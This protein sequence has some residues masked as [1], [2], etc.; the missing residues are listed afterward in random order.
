MQMGH[1]I[2]ILI[3]DDQVIMRKGLILLLNSENDIEV[4]GEAGDTKQTLQKI[5][6][7]QPDIVIME[8]A[9][10]KL[11]GVEITRRIFTELS[12]CKVIALSSHSSPQLIT[13]ILQA[14]ATAYLLKECAPEELLGAIHTVMTGG[15]YLAPSIAAT[16][17]ATLINQRPTSEKDEV[18]EYNIVVSS[19]KLHPPLFT[20]DLI[21]RPVLLEYLATR[22]HRLL[23]LV[24]APA[25]YGKSTLIS[26][27]LD[28][29]EWPCAWLTLERE[30]G[31][32]RQFLVY[33]AA[34]ISR[35][36]PK[37]LLATKSLSKQATLP[38][39]KSIALTL[40]NDLELLAKPFILVLDNFRFINAN[41]Q[42]H[43]LLQ[44]LLQ[45]TPMWL[46]LIILS[47]CDPLLGLVEHR[48]AG[49]LT[50]IRMQHLMFD[51][52]EVQLLH[53]KI[54]GCKA[55]EQKV[56]RLEQRMEGWPAGLRLL[57]L[58]QTNS[59]D[60][61]ESDENQID[62]IHHTQE[63]LINQVIDSL[64]SNLRKSLFSCSILERFCATLC[65]AIAPA[66]ENNKDIQHLDGKALIKYLTDHNLFVIPLD[67]TDNWF[68]F[69]P[70]FRELLREQ[71]SGQNSQQQIAEL[72]SRASAW[73]LS[74]G[75]IAEAERHALQ[76]GE[77][78]TV[79]DIIEHTYH[80]LR[81][82][83]N[84]DNN[85]LPKPSTT[86]VLEA[87]KNVHAWQGEALTRR[88]LEVLQLLTKRFQTKEIARELFVSTSTVKTHLK[89]LYQKLGVSS[90][91]QAAKMA[92]QMFTPED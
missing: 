61:Q 55:N 37:S 12:D 53:E 14:G 15:V 67:P 13:E 8:I 51:K 66:P 89:N 50:E 25:G 17:V 27:W 32:L 40:A 84:F 85:M 34:A 76:A 57:L 44:C 35:H 3:A 24:T 33:F 9:G 30:D 31:D 41:S 39:T 28:L 16:V 60:P 65:E 21:P 83:N 79:T 10:S 82:E 71:L 11:D 68:R 59:N 90:R 46:H 1:G 54:L 91:L 22:Q 20:N 6:A 58:A 38:A 52:T 75:L 73:F 74:Q 86:K 87:E 80:Q 5:K 4:I 45:Q 48:A 64:P 56:A 92:S 70:V 69:H 2:R 72:H 63:Y 18:E 42:V 47:R 62:G 88:E 26:N 29:C 77:Q 78:T 23:T 19:T 7:C 81:E 43:L 49:Q 36:F